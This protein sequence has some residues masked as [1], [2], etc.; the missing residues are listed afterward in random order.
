M[1]TY[2]LRSWKQLPPPRKHTARVPV[3]PQPEPTCC[4][5]LPLRN[6]RCQVCGDKL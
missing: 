4:G 5:K 6:G 2:L 3:R 1:R